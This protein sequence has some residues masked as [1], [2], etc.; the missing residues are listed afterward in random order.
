MEVKVRLP[1]TIN[2]KYASQAQSQSQVFF[3]GGGSSASSGRSGGGA[4]AGSWKKDVLMILHDVC[5]LI[6]F[7]LSSSCF[8][9]RSTTGCGW[10]TQ[11]LGFRA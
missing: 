1:V 3:I 8:P 10:D 2:V 4:V 6:R 5:K 9:N 7:G 11:A